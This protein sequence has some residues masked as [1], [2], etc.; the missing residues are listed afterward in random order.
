MDITSFQAEVTQVQ[1]KKLVSG[2]KE[3]KLT[4]ITSDPTCLELQQFIAE[5]VITVKVKRD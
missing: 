1:V 5:D 2:D 4:L 3:F